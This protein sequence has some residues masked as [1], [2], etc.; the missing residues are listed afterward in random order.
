MP[1]TLILRDF[2]ISE[3]KIGPWFLKKGLDIIAFIKAKLIL[4]SIF[5]AIYFLSTIVADQTASAIFLLSTKASPLYF[6]T[7]P[8]D[9]IASI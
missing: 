2:K 3:I 6:Q 4:L 5:I 8:C 9:L 7:L 1:S